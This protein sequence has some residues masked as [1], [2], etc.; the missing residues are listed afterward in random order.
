MVKDTSVPF[1]GSEFLNEDSVL[2]MLALALAEESPQEL[3]SQFA[4]THAAG[5]V[6]ASFAAREILD[7]MQLLRDLADVCCGEMVIEN[8]YTIA[9]LIEQ[10]NIGNTFASF[11]GCICSNRLNFGATQGEMQD[12]ESLGASGI[13]GHNL[14]SQFIKL[15]GLVDDFRSGPMHKMHDA[16]VRATKEGWDMK[17]VQYKD[18][19]CPLLVEAVLCL[20]DIKVTLLEVVNTLESIVQKIRNDWQN[21]SGQTHECK[22][23]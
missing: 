9:K 12:V 14:P 22:P 10:N 23:N 18:V 13:I 20:W 16:T 5:T 2:S 4:A 17:Q 7:Y 21:D 11:L 15:V 8:L 19:V 6:A 3:C 1:N